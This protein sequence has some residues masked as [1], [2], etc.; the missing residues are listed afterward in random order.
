L[1]FIAKENSQDGNKSSTTLT[2]ELASLTTSQRRMSN[3][4]SGLEDFI[5][6]VTSTREK[7]T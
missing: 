5:R 7:T 6:E 2:T 1:N 3:L 4:S